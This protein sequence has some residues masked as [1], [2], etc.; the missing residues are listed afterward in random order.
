MPEGKDVTGSMSSR[1]CREELVSEVEK[2]PV[3]LEGSPSEVPQSEPQQSLDGTPMEWRG[4]G[5][6]IDHSRG[7]AASG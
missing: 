6:R 1:T 7:R 2:F 5:V 3:V 4:R